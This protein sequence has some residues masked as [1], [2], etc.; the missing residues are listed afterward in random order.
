[1]QVK[2]K[3][4][5]TVLI[6]VLLFSLT[7]FLMLKE[8]E[9]QDLVGY[10]FPKLINVDEQ[11]RIDW[12]WQDT[13]FPNIMMNDICIVD[14]QTVAIAGDRGNF[15]K[16]TDGGASWFIKPLISYGKFNGVFF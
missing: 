9:I 15:L 12:T 10:K 13:D 1:M 11:S 4:D 14:T 8:V 2:H 5:L 3:R 7:V 6:G 16:T